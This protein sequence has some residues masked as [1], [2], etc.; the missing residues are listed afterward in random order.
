[1]IDKHCQ[2]QVLS[3]AKLQKSGIDPIYIGMSIVF[4]RFY[5]YFHLISFSITSI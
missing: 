2:L 4:N 1:M 5:V 3:Q